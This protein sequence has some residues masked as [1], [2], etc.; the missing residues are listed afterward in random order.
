MATEA[1]ERQPQADNVAPN[2]ENPNNSEPSA[3]TSHPAPEQQQQQQQES[4]QQPPS[5]STTPSRL[6]A[7][8][9]SSSAP[10]P[11]QSPPLPAR[12]VALTP[13]ARAQRLQ[14]L[15][16]SALT[17][18][19]AKISPDNFAACYPTIAAHAPHTLQSLQAGLVERMRHLCAQ[20]FA[21]TMARN[22]VVARLNELEA[23]VGD[24]A[25]RRKNAAAAATQTT[26]RRTGKGKG[27][28]AADDDGELDAKDASGGNNHKTVPPTPPH[29]LPAE[30]VLAAHLAPH[31]ASQQSQLNARLQNM[32]AANAGLWEAIA[33]QRA[34]IDG[35]LGALE[36]ALRDV[37]GAVEL[38][39]GVPAEALARE[40]RAVEV[41]M[42][43]V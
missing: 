15:F 27:R 30:A 34:E 31:L 18:T 23:L 19:L 35:L 38:M 11:P 22:D 3:P 36:G 43:D 12:P 24:A 2:A 25:L 9:S 10:Q 32:Q 42:A 13:G 14:T 4:E 29:L 20:E 6:P 17:H 21:K 28:A 37:D 33:A 8:T 16:D 7:P 1:P 26:S 40:S 39:D 41:E 5:S